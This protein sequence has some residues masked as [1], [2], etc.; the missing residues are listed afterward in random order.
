MVFI[1][2][3]AT[4][5]FQAESRGLLFFLRNFMGAGQGTGAAGHKEMRKM[6]VAQLIIR[7]LEN[8]G[9]QYMF[10]IPGE[11]ILDIMEALKDSS[12]QFITTRHEQGAA[13]MADVYGRLTGHAG[14]CIG[15]LG[16]GATN[17]ITG[18]ADANCDG[19]PLVAIT[20][21]VSS[22]KLHITAHQFLD[23]TR[24]FAPVTKRTKQVLEPETAEEIVRLA[25]KY[26]ENEM[27]GA[28]HIDI[29][30]N[31]AKMEVGEDAKPLAHGTSGLR[32]IAERNAVAKAY[33][34]IRGARNP[35]ILAGNGAVRSGAAE[36]L[37]RFA[38]AFGIP[39]VNTMMAKGIIPCDNEM[40]FS[41]VGIPQKDF[42]N[43]LLDHADVVIA[44]GYDLVE[45]DPRKW[46][47]SGGI[48]IVH[49][50]VLPADINKYYQTAVQVVGAIPESLEALLVLGNGKNHDSARMKVI[51]AEIEREREA[52]RT[53]D[54]FPM[55][56]QRMLQDVRSVL[57]PE[58]ILLSDVGAHKMWI[59]REYP[60]YKPNTC[61]ISNGFATMGF[62]LPGAV[63]AKLLYPERRVLAVTGDGGFLMNC[64]ELE[65]AVRMHTSVVVLIFHDGSYGLIKWKQMDRFGSSCYVDFGNPDFVKFAE[66][67][68]CKGYRIQKAA[69]L[70]PVLEDAFLQEVPSIIDCPVDY[71]ENTRLTQHLHEIYEKFSHA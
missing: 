14:V 11:E 63:A 58:D 67:F 24:I 12:I 16:P 39:V 69:D 9:V 50:A 6:N 40:Y 54:S 17:L 5:R 52:Y 26:A 2:G 61:L 31:V 45:Y 62:A 27:P 13:F 35:V 51:K 38:D 59:A 30:V 18:V 34:I 43:V 23:L 64:Q 46:N 37:T 28:T 3:I 57:A 70:V 42:G 41:T 47:S 56:P 71:D 1:V 19:A 21:Q 53:D 7:C 68:G 36:A 15:T 8:E 29:P 65:T 33:G 22:D 10:G 49:I 4:E 66:S 25:F 20:G 44:V 48:Q 60:C 55:K 32:E